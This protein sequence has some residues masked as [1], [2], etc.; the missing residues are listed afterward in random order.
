MNIKILISIICISLANVTIGQKTISYCEANDLLFQSSHNDYNNIKGEEFSG[1]ENS[2][3]KYFRTNT[4]VEDAVEGYVYEAFRKT[5][6]IFK[7]GNFK[8]S[9]TAASKM[10]S[11]EQKMQVCNPL[12]HF[13]YENWIYGFGFRME[14]DSV[15]A[16]SNIYFSINR[17]TDNQY[18]LELK[19]GHQIQVNMYMKITSS[20]VTNNYSKGIDKLLMESKTDFANIKGEKT[21]TD[22]DRLIEHYSTSYQIEG[23]KNQ[24]IEVIPTEKRYC[25]Q[26]DEIAQ[27]DV[28]L[29]FYETQR[30]LNQALGK[31]Y[32]YNYNQSRD[33]TE[34]YSLKDYHTMSYATL[35]IQIIPTTNNH[36]IIEV[37][38]IS[39]A[40]K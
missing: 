39:P 23:F 18:E 32:F 21:K 14:N 20:K 33:I 38:V 10:K 30:N 17:T 7:M 24:H 9:V 35:S 22:Y 13:T 26:T 19:Y 5:E 6:L 4:L 2:F 40:L 11:I 27:D 37:C 3:G 1:P 34:Y 12:I 25:F 29:K 36:Y 15:M 31:G 28:Q 8:D 16:T